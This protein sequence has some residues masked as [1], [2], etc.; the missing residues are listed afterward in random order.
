M[1][2]LSVVT[3]PVVWLLSASTSLLV[4]LL[5]IGDTSSKV[6]EEEIKSLIQ[7]GADSGEVREVEQDIMERALVMGDSRIDAIMTSRKDVASLTVGMDEEKMCIRDRYLLR[8]GTCSVQSRKHT[9]TV[10][11]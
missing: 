5:N 11:W 7:E 4:K 3:Y 2:L 8:G 1:K 9:R 6:T 10:I